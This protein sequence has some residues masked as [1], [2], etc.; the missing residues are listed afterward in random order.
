MFL[1]KG[2]KYQIIEL[3]SSCFF[4][5]L[6]FLVS[7]E[8]FADTRF[9]CFFPSSSGTDF[10]TSFLTGFVFFSSEFTLSFSGK[11]SLVEILVMLG[12][13]GGS[14]NLGLEIG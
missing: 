8:R 4:L 6:T 1:I 13:D 2:F 12:F 7:V 5:I 14:S 3:K 11:P 9:G 10:L